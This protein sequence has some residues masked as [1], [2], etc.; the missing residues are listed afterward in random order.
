MTAGL[1]TAFQIA[2][3]LALYRDCAAI[4]REVKPL[5]PV[6]LFCPKQLEARAQAFLSGFPGEVSYAVKANSEARV[7]GTLQA[8]GI[9]HFDVASLAEIASVAG[10]CPGATLHF[11]N[12]V[13]AEEAVREAYLRYGVRSFAL[14]EMSE[15]EK[16]WR[17]TGGDR[18]VT[19]SVRF[20]LG[21]ASAAYDFGS[22]FGADE[23]SASAL[24]A[25]IRRRG[26]QPALT[27]HPGSQCTDP[28]VYARYISAA[29]EIARR[30]DVS[31]AQLNVGGGFAQPY[32]NTPVPALEDYFCAIRASVAREFDAGI[33]LICEPGR[34]M[35]AASTSLLTRVVHVRDDG[36]TL[37]LNDGVYGGLQEQAIV[38][39]EFPVRAWR[40]GQVLEGTD[41]SYR[42]FGPTCDPV[43]RLTRPL[44]LPRGLRSGDYIEFGLL[45]AYGSA[46]ATRF[47]GF[48]SNCYVEL[49][50]GWD[51]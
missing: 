50:Q 39:L 15:L 30:A 32:R 27:F 1:A 21:H 6:Y 35:V 41:T 51:F 31:L 29:A 49:K 43:D 33:P 9:A 36:Q 5:D 10:C 18:C 19:Y 14:D 34:A 48:D 40:D 25:E 45:G 38:D 26:A 22:K 20:K 23:D 4:T 46:T 11:N 7:L 44:H 24:L 37:F 13:K 2:H 17:C 12:P 3:P 28:A 8:A 16:I 42:V 47:N